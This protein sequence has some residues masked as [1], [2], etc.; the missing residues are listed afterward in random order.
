MKQQIIEGLKKKLVLAQPKHNKFVVARWSDWSIVYEDRSCDVLNIEYESQQVVAF[1]LTDMREEQIKELDIIETK[2]YGSPPFF[3]TLD[4]M[5]KGK[6]EDGFNPGFCAGNG[7]QFYRSFFS[8]LKANGILF[9]NPIAD[10]WLSEWKED[11][12]NV[13]DINKCWIF[14]PIIL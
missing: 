11:Q 9:E 4:Y 8:A 13:W 14:Q 5:H 2:P 6:R 1:K 7:H 12:K 3:C 10:K